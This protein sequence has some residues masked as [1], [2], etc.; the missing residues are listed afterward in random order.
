MPAC[1]N[2]FQRPGFSCITVPISACLDQPIHLLLYLFQRASI[3]SN[4]QGS[5]Y[6]DDVCMG[7]IVAGTVGALHILAREAHNRAVIRGLN[8]I[9]LF[10]K[11]RGDVSP[12]TKM[13]LSDLLRAFTCPWY[14]FHTH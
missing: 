4:G 12:P 11:V 13:N 8:C 14:I 10:V 1:L 7:E 5:G 3:S 6:V 9:P 2:Q